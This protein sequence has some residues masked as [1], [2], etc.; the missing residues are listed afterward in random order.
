MTNTDRR[1]PLFLAYDHAAEIVGAIDGSDLGL[2]TV[3]S[4]FDVAALVDHIVGAGHRAAGIA[5]GEAGPEEFPQIDLR[6]APD[7]LR[8]AGKEA[9]S[10]WTDDRLIATVTMPWGETYDG[11]TLVNLYLAELAA[12]AWDLAAATG[13][14]DRLDPGL[15]G[16]ALEG[17]QAMLKPEYRDLMEKGSPYGAEVP[18]PAD[19][20]DWERFAAF[21]GRPPR[22]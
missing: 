7:E 20:T 15:A 13:H 11:Y 5:R 12:H 4:Q 9:R 21:M 8:T 2:P 19:A 16:P 3:C 17:A 22:P 6:D 18:A 1:T 14:L 10:A